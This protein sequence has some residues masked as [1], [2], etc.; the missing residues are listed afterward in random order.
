MRDDDDVLDGTRPLPDDL[1]RFE[2]RLAALP[3]P[4]EPDPEPPE[5]ALQCI[6]TRSIYIKSGSFNRRN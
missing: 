3:L 6:T 4:P 5:P 2:A 1:A